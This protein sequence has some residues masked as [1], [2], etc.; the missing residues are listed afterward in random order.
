MRLLPLLLAASL[1]NAALRL[2]L[3]ERIETTL[4]RKS[5]EPLWLESI[6][7]QAL[8]EI[9]QA[10]GHPMSSEPLSPAARKFRSIARRF[11]RPSGRTTLDLRFLDC[12]RNISALTLGAI[13]V[14][15]TSWLARAAE[16]DLWAVAAHEMAHRPSDFARRVIIGLHVPGLDANTKEHLVTEIEI[17]ADA[18]AQILLRGAHRNPKFLRRFLEAESRRTPSP[19]L[20]R[21]LEAM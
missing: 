14:V 4:T 9:Q 1:G 6:L 19:Q 16:D 20:R 17:N 3:D 21:R 18:R 13:V 10:C 15:N 2:D 7:W 11:L 8:G 5:A 12:G